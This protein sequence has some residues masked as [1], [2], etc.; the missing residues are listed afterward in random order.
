MSTKS[1]EKPDGP[2]ELAWV[3]GCVL[4][5]LLQSLIK[6]ES[7]GFSFD[8]LRTVVKAIELSEHP[9]LLFLGYP[10]YHGHFVSY[11]LF[12]LFLVSDPHWAAMGLWN[13]LLNVFTLLFVYRTARN[14]FSPRVGLL[15]VFLLAAHPAFFMG[16][17]QFLDGAGS[18]CFFST[19]CLFL[20]ERWWS[21]RRAR[22]LFGAMLLLGFGLG[23]QLWFVWFASALAAA[24]LLFRREIAARSAS[25]GAEELR[26]AAAGLAPGILP[27]AVHELARGFPSVE[28]ALQSLSHPNWGVGYSVALQKLLSGEF[29]LRMHFGE[30]LAGNGWYSPALVLALAWLTARALRRT[31]AWRKPFAFAGTLF[32]VLAL[33][34]LTIKSPDAPLKLA[35]LYPFPQVFLALAFWDALS[36][37]I[38]WPPP[39]AVLLALLVW[40]EASTTGTYLRRLE[41]GGAGRGTDTIY[42]LADWLNVRTGP[43]DQIVTDFFTFNNLFLHLPREKLRDSLPLRDYLPDPSAG[44]AVLPAGRAGAYLVWYRQIPRIAKPAPPFRKVAEFS[45]PGGG[46][47]VFEVYRLERSP[48]G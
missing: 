23:I 38:A 20:L 37:K 28:R 12:P 11:L 40:K 46:P 35:L 41:A 13:P 42:A 30:P 47:P 21:T 29:H 43:H 5:F 34:A 16:S 15:T 25:S 6:I 14:V 48:A 1:A 10:L 9:R 7:P 24:A 31:P 8:G 36:L 18:I 2:R 27:L 44:P 45:D 33:Q 26:A 32:G 22:F 3:G 39:P 19:G 4:L 17:R